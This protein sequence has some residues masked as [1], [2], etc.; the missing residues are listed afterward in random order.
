V[1]GLDGDVVIANYHATGTVTGEAI[2]EHNACLVQLDDG[3][4]SEMTDFYREP[5]TVARDWN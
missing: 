2:D 3:R 1:N 4:I 5:E